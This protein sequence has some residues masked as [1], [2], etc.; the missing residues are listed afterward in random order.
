MS[1]R[2]EMIVDKKALARLGSKLKFNRGLKKVIKAALRL[3][4]KEQIKNYTLTLRPKRP[5]NSKYRRTFKLK[6][7]SRKSV[8]K[9]ADKGW[10]GIW[11]TDGSADY[12][13]YVLGTRNQQ[14]AI[15]RGRWKSEEEV[16]E[17]V[18]PKL[19]KETEKIIDKEIQKMKGKP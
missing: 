13:K 7:S 10:I 19:E 5:P 17:N 2:L 18:G 4:E 12:D 11:D 6:K 9:T 1:N 14:A 8:P 15:H 16:I 3:I